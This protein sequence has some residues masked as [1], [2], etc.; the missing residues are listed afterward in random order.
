[1]QACPWLEELSVVG[2]KGA[3]N[4][5]FGALAAAPRALRSLAVGGAVMSWREE[6]AL[7]GGQGGW[8]GGHFGGCADELE[9]SGYS[10]WCVD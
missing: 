8:L 1:M 9:R 3:T 2:C 6:V 10:L 5:D 4:A 7:A